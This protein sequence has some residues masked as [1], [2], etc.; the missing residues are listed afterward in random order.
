MRIEI[1]LCQF[2][3]VRIKYYDVSLVLGIS[4]DVNNWHKCYAKLLH[5]LHPSYFF[6][7]HFA[8]A[9]KFWSTIM[10]IIVSCCIFNSKYFSVAN[11]KTHFKLIAGWLTL[12]VVGIRT[13]RVYC[14]YEIKSR[15]VFIRY[16]DWDLI[17][18][19]RSI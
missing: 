18:R 11:K 7:N 17:M 12:F 13:C 1:N 3:Y 4:L 19:V 10:P 15:I 9:E 5:I 16:L 8:M 2:F 14:L 6:L